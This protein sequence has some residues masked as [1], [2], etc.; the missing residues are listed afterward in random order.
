M[1]Q[2]NLDEHS[3]VDKAGSLSFPSRHAVS[4]DSSVHA[5]SAF[6]IVSHCPYHKQATIEVFQAKVTLQIRRR[7][8]N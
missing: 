1:V 6:L 7:A 5:G 8:G 3:L 4:I 2:N